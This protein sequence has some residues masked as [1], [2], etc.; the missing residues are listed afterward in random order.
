MDADH[1][2]NPDA[3]SLSNL[4]KSRCR[5]A[6]LARDARFDGLFYTGVKTTGIFCRPICPATAPHEKNV[7]YFP[8]ALAAHRAG[9]RPCLRCRPES[10][11]GSPAWRGTQTTLTRALRLID[12]G[13]WRNESLPQ[14][15]QRLGVSDRYLRKLFQQNLGISPIKY[16][17]FRRV[18]FAKQLLQQTTLPVTEI[19][20]MAGFGST[21]R[22]NAVFN[23]LLAL[24]PRQ[25]RRRQ[26]LDAPVSEGLTVFLSYRPPYD[27]AAV[28][29]FYELRQIAGLEVVTYS[30]YS[31]SFYHEDCEGL[32][33]ASH[34]PEKHGFRVELS[35][36]R[37]EHAL[38][39][40]QRIRRLL[41]LDANSATIAS[42]L[43]DHPLLS[44]LNCEGIRLPGMWS[45][46]EAGVRAILGQQV[47]VKAAHNLV[48]R[49]VEEL[50]KPLTTVSRPEADAPGILFPEPAAVAGSNL[51]FL[52]MP[53][54]R[55]EALRLLAQYIIEN[56]CG[57]ESPCAIKD[58]SAYQD[59]LSISG[60]GPWTVQYTAF[61]MGHPDIFLAGDLGVKNALK[62]LNG[63]S[64]QSLEAATV[65]P[66]GSYATLLLWQSL[67]SDTSSINSKLKLQ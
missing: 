19:A 29:D 24:N 46:F 3:L 7:D 65:S 56:S 59:W 17:N 45:P 12:N 8:T 58:D 49:L 10:A 41:D 50:G 33:T 5:K 47:S 61:R 13:E 27:W 66:W 6:R 20:F 9:L 40:I 23:E 11:P 67:S 32:F 57:G 37:A 25:L 48:T 64:K 53:G 26:K 22:F 1:Q 43:S 30:S 39:V 31:R 14:F 52:A 60:I 18:L 35:L 28:R 38:A 4:N 54:R 42:H 34:V 36:T 62:K 44:S 21:R 2:I 51:A 15:A 63:G 55:R 16:A